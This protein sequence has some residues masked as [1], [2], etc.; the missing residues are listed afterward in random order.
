MRIKLG[1]ILFIAAYAGSPLAQDDTD[2]GAE[3][4]ANRLP[5]EVIVTPAIKRS[6]L[7]RLIVQVEEDFFD[8]FNELNIDED[9]DILCYEYVPTM[10]HIPERVC[11]PLFMMEAR[12]MNVSELVYGAAPPPGTGGAAPTGVL[13]PPKAMRNAVAPQYD[14]LQ[15]KMEELNESDLELRSIGLALAKLKARLENFGKD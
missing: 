2:T 1:I 14:I 15:Q 9:Y 7:R 4:T 3:E 10:S 6:D 5:Y 11:E 8:K 12:G 13:L